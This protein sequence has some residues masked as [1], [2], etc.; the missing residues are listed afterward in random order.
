[1]GVIATEIALQTPRSHIHFAA[2]FQNQVKEYLLPIFNQIFE[3]SPDEF[4]PTWKALENKW[5]FKNGS[6]IKLC[7]CNNLQFNNLRGNKSD[8]FI[9]DECRDVDDLE[10]VVK[11]I[12]L[13]QLLS[14]TYAGKKI[15]LPSTPPT[16]PD[17]PYKKY[18]E[19]AKARGAYSEYTIDESWYTKEEVERF[20]EES[21]GRGSTTS[22]R[23]YFCK[24][25]TESS[26]QI[27]PEWDS[28]KYVGEATKDDFFQFFIP[29]QAM[30][31]GYR[32]FTA[33]CMGYY[34]FNAAKLVVEYEI[35]LR[36]NEF[37]TEK[38]A[39]EVKKLEALYRVSNQTRFRRIADNNNLNI[40]AD[41]ARIYKLPFIPVIKKS[42]K[43]YMVNQTRQFV[44]AGK[45]LINP[46]CKMLITSL[47]FGIWKKNR[48]D[49]ERSAELG[50]YDFVDALIYLI[51]GLIP[52]I[53]NINPVPPLYQLD[54]NKMMFPNN[55]VPKNT[56]PSQQDE[57]LKKMF[58]G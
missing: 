2:P 23:E 35:A 5:V 24:F 18:A 42:G 8:F 45:L 29:V 37:T 13:P 39:E 28:S 17:H 11:D 34:D 27:I 20:L 49:F 14:S 56:V 52:T 33:W 43:E 10:T 9:I 7:G 6:F 51:S 38:L 36:E 57:V 55:Q 47:E 46:R 54:V 53:Q 26:L 44:K 4:R 50:H 1:M 3:D 12:A 16:T 30:D 21:G 48:D 40:L 22:Q 15:V 31:V 41:L 25:V 19:K 58:L 32:D